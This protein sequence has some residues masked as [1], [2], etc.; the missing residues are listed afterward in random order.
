VVIK[1]QKKPDMGPFMRYSCWH[2]ENPP[3]AGRCPFK[4]IK[5]Q[6]SG[7]VT[8][9]F[10]KCNPNEC[11][12]QCVTDCQRG[13]YPKVGIGNTIDGGQFKAFKCVL[14]EGRAGL[15][16]NLPTRATAAEIAAVPE[17]AHQPTCVFTC[18]AKAM[19]YDTRVNI[20]AKLLQMHNDAGTD[21]VTGR[22]LYS[23]VGDGS[24]YWVSSKFVLAPPKADPY[25]EDHLTPMVSGLFASPL[26]IATIVPTL[27]A[28]ALLAVSARRTENEKERRTATEGEV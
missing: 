2:C 5:K 24:M 15:G 16:G 20:R 27:A 26:A 19:T 22:K 8:V 18:P 14:C 4:A 25:V 1:S 10:A 9:D 3:C 21:P 23:A 7:A 28:G 11:V 17:K 12:R 6:P 13:G